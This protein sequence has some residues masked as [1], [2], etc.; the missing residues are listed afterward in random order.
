[1]TEPK[2]FLEHAGS[3]V[4]AVVKNVIP[5]GILWA[6][7][8]LVTGAVFVA[9]S[10]AIGLMVMERGALLLGYLAIIPITIPFLGAALFGMHGLHR[11]AARAALELEHKFGLTAYVANT[12]L[13]LLEKHL[14][15]PVSNLPLEQLETKLKAVLDRY[16]GASEGKGVA[17]WVVTRV[18]KK[19]AT[20]LETYFLAAYRAELQKD[21][22]GGGVSIEK[23]FQPVRAQLSE[24]LAGWVMSPLNKQLALFMTLYVLVAGGW[25][26]WLYLIM[27]LFT[28]AASQPSA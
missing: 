25:W 3:V 17:A 10:F 7:I 13:G 21:G 27:S 8:G 1:V 18:K 4:M 14:G 26:Y 28:R 19:L 11:G 6:F 5:R 15:G 12:V 2:S 24:G 20:K 16:V 23:V 22:S 9:I